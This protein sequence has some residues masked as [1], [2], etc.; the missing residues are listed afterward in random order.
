MLSYF[1]D[2][3]FPRTSLTGESGKWIT[4]EERQKL[5]SFPITETK[6]QL[7]ERGLKFI[8]CIYAG[9]DYHN[10]PLLKKAISAYKF[11]RVRQLAN[12]L[13]EIMLKNI[14]NLEGAILCPVPLHWSR[15]FSRGFNQSEL[16]AKIIGEQLNIPVHNLIRRIRSTGHQVGRTRSER[17]TALKDAFRCTESNP[18]SRVILI[19]DLATTGA[20]LDECAK[21]LKMA[22]AEH[23]EGWVIAHG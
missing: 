21:T 12:D 23:V 5:A 3:I 19:D 18:S 20:T 10:C 13:S 11:K 22:G 4:D 1:L 2:L 8:D 14:P 17:L 9:S 15:Q 7:L 6:K 16:L